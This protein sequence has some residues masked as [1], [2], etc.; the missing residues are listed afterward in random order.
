MTS[1]SVF[2]MAALAFL[3]TLAA[4]AEDISAT[5]EIDYDGDG[6]A[7]VTTEETMA[8]GSTAYDLLDAAA[9]VEAETMDWGVFV[10]GING[11]VANWDEKGTWWSFEVNGEMSDLGV[12]GYVLVDGD[13]VTMSFEGAEEGVMTIVLEID[14]E[15]DGIIDKTIYS[16]MEEG[17]TAFDLLNETTEVAT[18]ES[19]D[20]HG[21]LVVGIDGVMSNYAEDGTWWMFMV[22]GALSD[23]TM[24]RFVLEQGQTVTMSMGGA[25]EAELHETATP[26]V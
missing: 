20:E 22:D 1:R 24:D 16:E 21:I 6:V 13:V 5:L 18:E 3:L 14:Y 10:V 8:D 2:L 4:A 7:D 19:G 11:V 23:L 26:T 9:D 17:S 12:G 15:G 25:E